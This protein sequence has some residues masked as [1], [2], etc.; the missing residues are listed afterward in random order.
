LWIVA[1][2]KLDVRRAARERKHQYAES[3]RKVKNVV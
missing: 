3:I 2:L 1:I